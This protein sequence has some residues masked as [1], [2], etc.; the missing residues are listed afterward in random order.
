MLDVLQQAR[1]FARTGATVLICG[2]SGSG[3]ELVAQMLHDE[4][5]R[6][7]LPYVRLNCAALAESLVESELFGHE[8]GAFTGAVARRQGKFEAAGGGTL[9]LDEISEVSPAVQSKLLRV[10]E[11]SEFERVGGNAPQPVE[12][13]VIAATNRP[14][15][16]LVRSGRFRPDL[17]YRLDVLRIEVPPLRDR[18]EDIPLLAQHFVERF[19][20]DSPN[21]VRGFTTAALRALTEYDWPGNV[22]QLRNLVHRSCIVARKD[23]I[24]VA[25]LPRLECLAPSEDEED[26]E[27]DGLSLA[28][29]ERRVI[30]QRL[31]KHQGNKSAAAAALGVTPRTLRN[32]VNEYRRLGFA[33]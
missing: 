13:R 5:H 19:R 20:S 2:E 8:P 29:I 31:E 18:I 33:C 21:G 6:S 9:F 22:R 1:L 4:S 11:E 16:E 23:L 24:D 14:L 3:K 12:A 26:S 10:L 30:L 17:F 27:L 28:E 32:K 25:D 7:G 15:P